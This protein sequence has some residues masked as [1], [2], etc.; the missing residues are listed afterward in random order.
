MRR[1]GYKFLVAPPAI[2]TRIC[3]TTKHTL[4]PYEEVIVDVDS[5][6]S[7]VVI[8]AFTGRARRGILTNMMDESSS[9]TSPSAS[10]SSSKTRLTFEIPSRGLL[11]FG[12]EIATLTRGSAI[13]HH[14]YIEDRKWAGELSRNDPTDGRGRLVASDS[15][16]VTAYAL[17]SIAERGQLFV[18][19]GDEVYAG[20]VIG[21]NSKSGDLE[22]NPIRAKATSNIR[23]VNKDEKILLAPPKRLTL[24][25][26]IGYMN[27]DELIEVTPLN[28][29]LRKAE[30]DP[31]VRERAARTRK[32]KALAAK[33]KH[34]K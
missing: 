4:E 18:S 26:L 10:S 17:S 28:V 24:E 11:G 16:K 21:E 33:N 31:G 2:V 20:M 1:E 13:V 15:G 19:P 32:K 25:E 30:L 9:S 22:V 27:E 29:R 5:E 23:T 8:D 6:Y 14:A 12:P 3:P 34:K 7:G